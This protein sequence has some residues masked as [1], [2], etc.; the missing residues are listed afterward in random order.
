MNPGVTTRSGR[1]VM[2]AAT[3]IIALCLCCGCGGG[4]QNSAV[5]TSWSSSSGTTQSGS[6]SG[7]TA[8][9]GTVVDDSSLEPLGNVTVSLG[10][11]T[12]VTDAQGNYTLTGVPSGTQT[13]RCS[14]SDY[15]DE[16]QSVTLTEGQTSTQDIGMS[17]TMDEWLELGQAYNWQVEAVQEDGTVTAGPVWSFTA[18]ATKNMKGLEITQAIDRESAQRAA[19]TF[20]SSNGQGSCTIASVEPILGRSGVTLAYAFILSPAGYVIV[21]ASRADVLPPVLAYSFSSS[22][23]THSASSLGMVKM[24][25][26]DVILR[27]TALNQKA[28]LPTSMLQKNRS[29]WDISLSGKAVATG[30]TSKTVYGPWL[31]LPTWGQRKPYYDLCPWDNVTDAQCLTGCVATA[32][33]QV[34]NYWQSPT[35]VTFTSDDDYTTRT[36]KI[37]I[38]AAGASFSGLS[39]NNG[40][41][42]DEAKAKI[43]YAMGVLAKMNYSSKVSLA[44]TLTVGKSMTRMGYANPKIKRYGAGDTVDTQPII[45]DLKV[46][47]HGY[48]VVMSISSLDDN[49][50]F[51][52]GHAIIAD[53]YNDYTDKFHLN[54]G[55]NG[56][57]DGWYSLPSG[58]P[59]G[60]NA[61]K[62]YVYNLVPSSKSSAVAKAV[63]SVTPENP[64]PENG[65][66]KVALDEELL[67]DE[68]DNAASYN[69]FVWKA[70][71]TKPSTPT[72]SKL[73]YAAANSCFLEAGTEIK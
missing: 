47:P 44:N 1:A 4:S 16:N 53:G 28:S 58:M 48:P 7:V 32:F 69:C 70:G 23:S 22:F 33:A 45:D 3:L 21:P 49:G 56:N 30:S 65:E 73:P 36:R 57:S 41:P 35:S 15:G 64:Y 67:W 54:M 17:S 62:G 71:S 11:V 72:F 63:R 68:C 43:C 46:S 50:E 27:L 39:Y 51:D 18:D 29:Q 66:T 61:I 8:V 5:P 59:S 14:C 42:G 60:Y 24:V 26:N 20:L 13:I 55:W 6:T 40:A 52:G 31:Y 37:D 38:K 25:R 9:K 34:L 12:A 19:E 10:T 2:L